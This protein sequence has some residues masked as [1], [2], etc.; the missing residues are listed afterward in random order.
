M[1][2]RGPGRALGQGAAR[3]LGAGTALGLVIG[4]LTQKVRPVYLDVYIYIIYP[5]S[6][7]LSKEWSL[8]DPKRNMLHFSRSKYSLWTSRI[9]TYM[10]Y[11][12]KLTPW[13]RTSLM[14]T[15][16]V[17]GER[18]PPALL[19]ATMEG[20]PWN[21][22][23]FCEPE[24]NRSSPDQHHGQH[25]GFQGTELLM[26][27]FFKG[28]G[29]GHAGTSPRLL[30]FIVGSIDL[31]APRVNFMTRQWGGQGS[32]CLCGWQGSEQKLGSKR[33]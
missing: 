6:Q 26:V 16:H 3:R 18:T 12:T 20:L 29:P 31:A 28:R 4:G 24:G 1:R 8:G 5:G 33:V 14:K 15:L 21:S 30:V 32:K 9:Y 27:F 11:G 23:E 7:R 17:G 10:I 13:K 19:K 2:L 25:V 22:T